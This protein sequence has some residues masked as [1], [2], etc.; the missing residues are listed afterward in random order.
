[1]ASISGYK[2]KNGQQR[3]RVQLYAGTNPATGKA[4]NMK[5]DGFR[6]YDEA[7]AWA[8]VQAGAAINNPAHSGYRLNMRIGDWLH[9][10]ITTFKVNVKEGSMIVYRYNIEHYLVPKI[11]H[12]T[13]GEYT[14]AVHQ[15]FIIEMLDHG[16]KNGAP[17]SRNTVNIIN[18]TLS[19]ALQ[20]AVK[21]GYIPK[22]NAAGVEFP[23]SAGTAK[24]KLHYWTREQASTF[25]DA[26]KDEKEPVWYYFF[27]TILDLGLRKGEAMALR[28]DDVDFTAN[29]VEINKNRL[30]RAETGEHN[31]EIILDDPKF[32]TSNRTI[33]MT[34]RL[35]AALI[36]LNHE[37]YPQPTI[38]SL[39]NEAR[40]QPSHDFIFRFVNG[41]FRGKVLRD[42]STNGAFERIRKRVALPR[43]V[44][45]D[46]R[47]TLGV[48]LRESGVPLED[49][50][51][52]LGHKDVSTTLIY[53]EVTPA[54]KQQAT[55]KL[56]EFLADGKKKNPKRVPKIN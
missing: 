6:S 34:D 55:V 3:Y 32:P 25:L 27:L 41:R 47:H 15:R 11:G 7:N 21:L 22:N 53:A 28:W 38:V 30:Y 37:W 46:L 50:R 44:I 9:D 16:G 35:R 24:R 49:I 33:Y 56:N 5:R 2:L 4:K 26:A 8:K 39:D 42:R 17:L 48:F 52:V 18:G 51:D 29:T 20:K 14:P 54:I 10:W 43:I 23:R 12:Y 19:N 45:H 31:G 13:F 1:M 40:V 36:D